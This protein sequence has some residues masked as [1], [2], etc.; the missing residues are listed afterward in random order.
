MFDRAVPLLSLLVALTPSVALADSPWPDLGAPAPSTR[1]GAEDAAVVIAIE[2][3]AYLPDVPGARANADAWV[4]WFV[5]AR[6]VPAWRVVKRYDADAIDVSMRDA[7]EEAAAAVGP[8]GTLWVVYIGHGAPS[9][10][11]ND[12][13]LVGADAARSAAGIYGRSLSR[14]ELLDRLQSGPQARTVVLLDACF[15]GQASDGVPLL[16]DLQPVIPVEELQGAEGVTV[17]SAT[18]SGQFAGPLP[19]EPRPAFS[20]LALGA[21]RG[22]ADTD[23]DGAVTA[24]E[25]TH[26]TQGALNLTVSGRRQSPLLAGPD[27]V[28]SRGGE[29]GPDL[30]R[31]AEILGA[32]PGPLAAAPARGP[33]PAPPAAAIPLAP[34]PSVAPASHAT[35]PQAPDRDQ[36]RRLWLGFEGGVAAGD[37]SRLYEAEAVIGPVEDEAELETVDL[38]YVAGDLGS[39]GGT[40]KPTGVG[41][42]ALLS[43]GW[44]ALPSAELGL[45]L[46]V[47][48]GRSAAHLRA[49]CEQCVEP[50]FSWSDDVGSSQVLV[51]PRFRVYLAS[52]RR[53]EPYFA[54]ALQLRGVPGFH[55]DE[56]YG[57][58]WPG[59]PW[60]LG[61]GLAGGFGVRASL[62]SGL[63][64]VGGFS[65][66]KH[67]SPTDTAHIYYVDVG[68]G[69]PDLL[70]G[71][72]LGTVAR[73]TLGLEYGLP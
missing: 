25:L 33:A 19:G 43:L 9:K 70:T 42:I 40:S 8:G 12:G 60:R 26:Y 73:A 39:A 67:V 37:V 20:Y 46:G 21:V 59:V 18:S 6:G 32:V 48:T 68:D 54:A 36:G 63:R 27:V 66:T 7:F 13:L 50:E 4:R 58:E 72:H 56:L 44:R 34:T 31:L 51:E 15:A 65:V 22:W 10:D 69:D 14:S 11:G 71:V 24:G 30:L 55:F 64:L 1:D 35:R 38:V 29:P 62:A 23:G 45:G 49:T 52:G 16:P 41:G 57:V 47:Q 5:Q 28:L 3:Y 53:F 2:D 61:T 17:L